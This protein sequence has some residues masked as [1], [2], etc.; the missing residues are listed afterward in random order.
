MA[1]LVVVAEPLQPLYLQVVAVVPKE[2]KAVVIQVPLLLQLAQAVE[3]PVVLKA[4]VTR[5]H[6]V[7]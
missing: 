5:L 2:K 7:L 6:Q 3:D 4:A 1:L